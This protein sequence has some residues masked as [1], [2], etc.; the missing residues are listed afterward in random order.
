MIPSL[1]SSPCQINAH[2]AHHPSMSRIR[3]RIRI[4][5]VKTTYILRVLGGVDSHKEPQGALNHFKLTVKEN[6][7]WTNPIGHYPTSI[8]TP[9][10]SISR[11]RELK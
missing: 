7:L 4:L 2:Q 10:P 8:Q 6:S 9:T 1:P 11:G 5:R 3:I